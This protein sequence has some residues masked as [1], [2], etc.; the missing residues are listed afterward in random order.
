MDRKRRI[1]KPHLE[2]MEKRE[3]LTVGPD[4]FAAADQLTQAN[5]LLSNFAAT[6][7]AGSTSTVTAADAT[8]AVPTPNSSQGTVTAP[9]SPYLIPLSPYQ[10]AT[11]TAAELANEKYTAVFTG[12]YTTAAPRFAGQAS[13]T[14]IQAVGSTTDELHGDIQ[15]TIITPQPLT[16]G[17]MAPANNP[18]NDVEGLAVNLDKDSAD[19]AFLSLDVFGSPSTSLNS[20]GLPTN[21]QFSYSPYTGAGSFT[22]GLYSLSEGAGTIT[23]NYK[24][25]KAKLPAG[26]YSKGTVTVV[27]QGLIYKTGVT[28]PFANANLEETHS[29]PNS[30]GKALPKVVNKSSHTSPILKNN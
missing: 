17:E 28:D 30:V 6:V 14:Y 12:T 25:S 8:N 15:L 1:A 22:G 13:Q 4:M 27:V 7:A 5:S 18:N 9:G 16:P 11:P 29:V 21:L 26:V 24:P 2:C 20:A 3:L 19:G 23:I 10:G